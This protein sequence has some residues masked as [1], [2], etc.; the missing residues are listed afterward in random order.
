MG[1]HRNIAD[2]TT[3]DVAALKQQVADSEKT[4]VALQKM[5]DALASLPALEQFVPAALR[6]VADAFDTKDCAYFEHRA[7]DLIR[8]RYWFFE[9]TVF[10]PAGIRSFSDQHDLPE[11]RILESGFSVPDTYLGVPFRAR[12]KASV[13]NHAVQLPREARLETNKLLD[14]SMMLNVPLV[15]AGEADGALVIHRGAGSTYTDSEIQLAERLAQPLAFAMAVDRITSSASQVAQAKEREQATQAQMVEMAKSDAALQQM[16][17]TLAAMPDLDNFIPAALQIIAKTFEAKDCQYYEHRRGELIRLRYWLYKDTVLGPAEVAA[18][19]SEDFATMRDNAK[20]FLVPDSHLGVPFRQRTRASVV[21]HR[22][23][24][25]RTSRDEFC[26]ATGWDLE[27]NVPLVVSGEANGA[28]VI[29]RPAGLPFTPREIALAE[30]LG[31]QLALAMEVDRLSSA[32]NQAVVAQE[33]ERATRERSAEVSR[34]AEVLKQTVDALVEEED[35][36]NFIGRMLG[37]AST[38]LRAPVTE[39]WTDDGE[40]RTTL[41][42]VS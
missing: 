39:Y 34:H 29:S 33:R 40:T 1:E 38:Q 32:A 35:F 27:L 17:D 7:G 22:K 28:L 9:E 18:V 4:T 30:R 24:Y 11:L 19:E 41:E 20:G 14:W 5:V 16:T 36:L 2:E 37:I 13:R 21:D 3:T 23:N 31:Q 15:I 10:G 8:L 42:A 26:I 25:P 6:I 12:T